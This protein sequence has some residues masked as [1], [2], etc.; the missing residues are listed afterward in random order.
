M[1]LQQ[2]SL[3]GFPDRRHFRQEQIMMLCDQV[4]QPLEDGRRRAR[5]LDPLRHAG[6]G[7]EIALAGM[8]QIEKARGLARRQ[9]TVL[10]ILGRHVAHA[11]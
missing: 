8:A 4:Q 6:S 1:C 9:L 5:C 11:H 3:G 2:L 10:A 7:G